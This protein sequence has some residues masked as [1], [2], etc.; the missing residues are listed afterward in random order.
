MDQKKLKHLLK[1]RTCDVA[2]IDLE[3]A[4]ILARIA[5][6]KPTKLVN[7]RGKEDDKNNNMPIHGNRIG[8]C[9]SIRLAQ[10]YRPKCKKNREC[11]LQV[12]NKG[13]MILWMLQKQT[14][15]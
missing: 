4:N 9:S 2:G 3:F 13:W 7:H 11:M 10:P 12:T 15:T 6:N 5:E 14:R 1:K 8:S